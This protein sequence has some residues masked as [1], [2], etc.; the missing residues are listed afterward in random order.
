[1]P[2]WVG[3]VA[4]YS[5]QGL[6]TTVLLAVVTSVASVVV[7]TL[8]GTALTVPSRGVQLPLRAYVEVWRGLPI[9]VTLFFVF[10]ALPVIGIDVNTFI[11]AA[12]GL[13][14]WGT[15]NVA[16]IARG[17]VQSIP[18]GQSEGAGALGFPW[19]Q[20][21][22]YVVLPQA[23]RRMLPPLVSLLTNL[24]QATTLGAVIGLLEVLQAS[25]RS[26]ERL[27]VDTGHSHAIPIFGAILVV[28]FL[29]CFPLT[30]IARRLERRMAQYG[31]SVEVGVVG[32][33]IAR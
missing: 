2:A 4:S 19:S 22:R 13:S 8:I 24:I 31:D 18:Y 17:A 10:F 6:L 29:I 11:A 33:N 27:L 14:L 12:I 21:M 5:A 26:I 3:P 9:I 23:V 1:M 30:V 20:R 16:E 7:G 25:Q 32:E 28:F 15:A